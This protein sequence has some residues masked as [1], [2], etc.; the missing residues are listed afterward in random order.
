MILAIS[1]KIGA[2]KDT[3]GNI[4]Q[5]LTHCK[6]D[7]TTY[8]EWNTLIH[9]KMCEWKIKK[10]AYKL[11]QVVALITGCSV[12]DLESQEFK[13]SRLGEEWNWF[14]TLH[15]DSDDNVI[16]IRS[17]PTEEAKISLPFPNRIK[18][19]TYREMLQRVGT[20]AMRNQIHENVWVNAL[21]ADYKK[22]AQIAIEKT[23]G[24]TNSQTPID[25]PNWII[26][27]MRFPNELKAVEDRGGITIRIERFH[28]I[29]IQK[30]GKDN[31]YVIEKF[32]KTNQKHIDLYK[33]E[34]INQHPSETALD[35]ANFKYTIDNN[36]TI[37]ELIKKVKEILI[38]EEMI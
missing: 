4:I 12:E 32:D 8:E 24:Y 2:G 27:D 20:E 37:E 34:T 21:F 5:Y 26:T 15:Y 35:N 31:D 28:N 10:F 33:A 3:V 13:N 18:P 23:G 9:T 22:P 16:F 7:N 25:F 30:S 14:K 6:N 19:Y 36:G 17:T 11:K 38:L 1:G 29:K